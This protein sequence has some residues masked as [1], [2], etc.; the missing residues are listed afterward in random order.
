MSAN[1]WLASPRAML[2]GL[3][4]AGALCAALGCLFIWSGAASAALS[5]ELLSSF[6]SFTSAQ[7]LAVDQTTGDV[8]VYDAGAGAIDKFT[9]AGVPAEFS[10]LKA[11]AIEGVG[12]VGEGEGQLAVDNSAGPAHGD[13]YLANGSHVGI[14]GAD[15]KPLGELSEAAGAPWGEPC[16]VAV[17]ATGAVYVGLNP[18]HVNRYVPAANPVKSSNYTSSL[19][20][21]SNVCNIAVDGA[22]NTYADARFEGPITKY[23]AP[24][25][26]ALE[27]PAVGSEVP[28]DGRTLA[29]DP[30]DNDLYAAHYAE[31]G[32]IDSSGS[33]LGAFGAP[34]PNAFG[35]VRGVAVDGANGDV[36]VADD[37]HARIDVFGPAVV[38][39]DVSA[40]AVSGLTTTTVTLNGSVDPDA[41]AVTSCEFEYGTSPAYGSSAPCVPLPGSGSTSEAVTAHVSGLEQNTTYYYR[42]KSANANGANSSSGR[43]FT[44]LSPPLVG[45]TWSANVGV[46]TATVE[47]RL[48]PRGFNTTYRFEYG[49]GTSYGNTAPV[50]DGEIATSAVTVTQLLTSLAAS[51]TYHYRI[52]ATNANGTTAGPDRTFT[53]APAPT[54]AAADNCPNA[55]FRV[56]GLSANL[57][58]CRAYEM[59]SPLD[60]NGGD[61]DGDGDTVVAA[62][63]GEGVAYASR[64]GFGDSRG[65]G[66][67]GLVQYLAT[68]GQDAWSTHGITPTPAPNAAQLF[69][70]DTL[71]M[72]FS[73][74]LE[75][76]IVEG[77]D[78]P[79]ASGGAPHEVNLYNENT[80]TNAL[81]TLTTPLTSQA[82]GTLTMLFTLRGYSA[83]LGVVAFETSDNLLPGTSGSQQK[84]YVWNHG[85]LELA[86]ILPDGSIPAEGSSSPEGTHEAAE[87]DDTVSRDG[88]RIIFVVRGP[89]GAPQLYMRR[90]G[91]STAWISQSEGSTPVA[92]PQ[93]VAFQA[94]TPDG[95]SVFFTTSDRL[96]DADPGG[97][98]EGLYR[99]TDSPN[100]AS[101]SNLTFIARIQPQNSPAVP[102]VSADGTH[103]YFYTVSQTRDGTY[104][105]DNGTVHFVAPGPLSW[106]TSRVSTDGTRLAFLSGQQLTSQDTGEDHEHGGG[107]FMAMYVYN[108]AEEKLNCVSCPPSGAAVT[109]NAE[110]E[111]FAT[112]AA[113]TV[114]LPF[115]KRFMSEDGR[116]VFFSTADALVPQDTNHLDD[117]Y[118]YNTETKKVSLLSSGSGEAGAWFA[119]ASANG[120]DVF[121]LTRQVLSS[122]DTDT[123]ID[124]YDARVDGGQPEPPPSPVPCDG[125]ACQGV[126]S[127]APSFNT[128][129]GFSGLGNVAPKPA[130]AA[131]KKRPPHKAAKT[132]KRKRKQAKPKKQVKRKSHGH[133]S[134][135][136]RRTIG[137]GR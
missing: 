32:Q 90:D 133:A 111:P 69:I 49:T 104:L 95:K 44:T 26:S 51:T 99:Y 96:L 28:G 14:Y 137:R 20:D 59:V 76:A 52:A 118:E 80:A 7:G 41:V 61:L 81:Q 16:G 1:R 97:E 53:T 116:Y 50:P 39:P 115:R 56:G 46:T 35:N 77:Y 8:Y 55:A 120:S 122:E 38:V 87:R 10:A 121:F 100:P 102:D 27:A 12:G 112:K 64:T 36:Y 83:D 126:P 21:L 11:D 30:S 57:P 5:H 63:D 3:S 47:A 135:E 79:G 34:A 113:A 40:A 78:L 125:D 73:Q 42:L 31:V 124:L 136:G 86:G 88:S 131:K 43:E 93:E 29:V 67:V 109:S 98:G 19:W 117:V 6:G 114:Q 107:S 58:D 119:D 17:D 71:I 22:G 103:V 110:V 130:S 123:L 94:A 89:G 65:S 92:E 23:A 91:T 101:E 74:Q 18:G 13:I 75:G 60:K 9:A 4:F 45:R 85:S 33:V 129:S 128:A 127:A 106:A 54:E 134:V 48:D 105:W 70:G 84:L 66:G 72:A 108:E 68:R 82:L 25:F 24:Q 15:G 2:R 62:A 132:K 37:E